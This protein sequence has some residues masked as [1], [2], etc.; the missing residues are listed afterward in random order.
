MACVPHAEAEHNLETRFGETL[1]MSGDI[2]SI[3]RQDGIV[4]IFAD[5]VTGNWNIDVSPEPS[6]L[7]RASLELIGTGFSEAGVQAPKP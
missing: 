5:E 2:T 4:K 1:Q 3:D 7:N 6:I